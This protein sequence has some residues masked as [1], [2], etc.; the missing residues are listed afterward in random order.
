MVMAGL[1]VGN[2]KRKWENEHDIHRVHFSDALAGLSS[3][4]DP[5]T[6]SFGSTPPSLDPYTMSFGFT[7]LSFGFTPC[8]LAAG[9]L[10]A[11]WCRCFPLLAV[12][13]P[14]GLSVAVSWLDF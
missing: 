10:S 5:Y 7:P 8:H 11:L 14:F 6:V 1:D 4:L 12:I 2:G 3:S 9:L 13:W